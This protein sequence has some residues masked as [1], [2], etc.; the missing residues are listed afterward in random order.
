M[1]VDGGLQLRHELPGAGAVGLDEGSVDVLGPDVLLPLLHGAVGLE[2]A[3]G[4]G[5]HD[6]VEPLVGHRPTDEEL[7]G[8]DV[9]Q[10]EWLYL[11]DVDAHLSVYAGALNTNYHT[12]VSWE[13][14]DVR[15]SA[16]V[17]AQVV[18]RNISYVVHEGLL[19][20]H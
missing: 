16:T 17:T 3:G 19:E 4:G 20:L 9:V 2:L 5:L 18:G 6:L 12:E 11:G 15:G 7:A 13:P 8:A 1:A 14:G 10:D